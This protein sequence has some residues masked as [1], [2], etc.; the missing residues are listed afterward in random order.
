MEGFSFLSFVS[1]HRFFNMWKSNNDFIKLTTE[2][3]GKG[4]KSVQYRRLR[5]VIYDSQ[6]NLSAIK[7]VTKIVCL[8]LLPMFH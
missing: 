6:P 2:K 5:I 8:N 7:Q 4:T 1:F 3:K